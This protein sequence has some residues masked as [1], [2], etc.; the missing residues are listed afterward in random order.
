MVPHRIASLL[1]AGTE[2]LYALGLGDRVVAISHE[3]DYPPQATAKPR[4]TSARIDASADSAQIDRQVNDLAAAGAPLY[5]V[6]VD[7]L[8]ALGP[9]LIVTQ[10]Q[11]DVCAVSE[12]ALRAAMARRDEF[13]S[14]AV[15]TLNPVSLDA[16]FDDILRVGEAAGCRSTAQGYVAV[17]RS[18]VDTIRNQTVSLAESVRPRVI[19]LEWI[20]PPIVA[21]NWMPALV[22]IAGGRNGLT[23]AGRRSGPS[24]WEEIVAYDPD[25][26]VVMPCGFPLSRTRSEIS[27][28]RS[29]PDW[30]SLKAVTGGRVFAAD[31]NAYFNR[32]GPRIVDSLEILAGMILPTRFASFAHQYADAWCRA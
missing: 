18:R 28:L 12:T 23:I 13:T 15:V 22:E 29:L 4:V 16:I 14:T 31:G 7:R 11:C 8:A 24:K 26:L 6:D 27:T 20:E 3:C 32:S 1:A 25:V 10:A 2:M 21:A 30:F 19:C 9:D 17:L 5:D